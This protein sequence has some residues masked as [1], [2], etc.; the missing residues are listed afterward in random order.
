MCRVG[1]QH[2]DGDVD[3]RHGQAD[4]HRL[5]PVYGGCVDQRKDQR[6][7]VVEHVGGRHERAPEL[8]LTHLAYVPGTWAAGEA[9]AQTHQ[10]GARVQCGHVA[11]T[12]EHQLRRDVRYVGYQHA[13]L[14]PEPAQRQR[15]QHAAQ[16][17]EQEQQ[18]ACER[19]QPM[20]FVN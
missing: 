7:D 20:Y 16:R 15:R 18:A 5:P 1:Y 19:S 2:K 11:G 13:R 12:H 17:R 6:P 9:H 14:V 4:E 10:H 8:G 3:G